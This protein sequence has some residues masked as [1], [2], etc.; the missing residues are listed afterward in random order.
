ML[1]VFAGRV[2]MELR[3]KLRIRLKKTGAEG[4]RL[5]KRWKP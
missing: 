1:S 2:E 5:Q 3:K 4:K